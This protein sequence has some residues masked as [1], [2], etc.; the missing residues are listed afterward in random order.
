[1]KVSTL[2]PTL[3]SHYLMLKTMIHLEILMQNGA[4]LPKWGLKPCAFWERVFASTQERIQAR[5]RI[6][7]K[8][9]FIRKGI[10]RHRQSVVSTQ[11][12]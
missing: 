4:N 12:L 10:M 2:F 3:E 6:K 1:M 11:S 9:K 7:D 5:A 8:G